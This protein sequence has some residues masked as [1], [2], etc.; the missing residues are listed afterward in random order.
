VSLA[1]GFH[2]AQ[3]PA[4]GMIVPADAQFVQAVK[5][6]PLPGARRGVAGLAS[7]PAGPAIIVGPRDGLAQRCA[8]VLLLGPPNS[9]WGLRLESP[10]RPLDLQSSEPSGRSG[11]SAPPAA[12]YAFQQEAFLSEGQWW[13]SVDAA[14]LRGWLLGQEVGR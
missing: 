13:W 14:V 5:V 7:T 2:L 12:A 10:P 1:Y 3:L 8:S 9:L 4:L 11:P 6:G